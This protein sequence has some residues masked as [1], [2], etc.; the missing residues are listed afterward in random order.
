MVIDWSFMAFSLLCWQRTRSNGVQ[1][2]GGDG[3]L[4]DARVERST[5]I[6]FGHF[7]QR[8]HLDPG[9]VARR[10]E[11]FEPLAA[12]IAHRIHRRLEEFARVEF[13]P[14]LGCYLSE[15]R[16]HRQPAIGV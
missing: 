8:D 6:A 5:A 11:L 1:S 3:R 14:G 4:S 7:G 12:E 9:G 13:A 15:C 2:F 10:T 16:G